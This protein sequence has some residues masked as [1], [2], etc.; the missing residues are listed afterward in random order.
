MNECFLKLNEDKTEFLVLGSRQQ[1]SKIKKGH[2]R[3]GSEH[4]VPTDKAR[5]LGVI[6]NSTMTHDMHISNIVKSANYNLRNL[7]AIRNYLTPKTTEQLIHAFVTSYL[8]NCN[9]LLYGLP[10]YQIHRLQKIQNIAARLVTKYRRSTRTT[11]Q[12]KNLHWLPL[13]QHIK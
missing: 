4:I 8:D 5:N 6:F 1:L 13:E 3:V 11:K 10:Q 12:L 7:R 9:S 2:I